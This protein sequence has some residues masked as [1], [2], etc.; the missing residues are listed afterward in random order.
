[1]FCGTLW[2]PPNHIF[3]DG[4]VQGQEPPEDSKLDLESMT[5][6]ELEF[7]CI[8]RGFELIQDDT[9]GEEALTHADYVDAA[10]RCLAIEEDM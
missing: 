6:E 4:A 1:M 9:S 2:N 8:E 10:R 3:T 7:I 5:Q